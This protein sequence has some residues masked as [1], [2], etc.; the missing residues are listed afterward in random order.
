[1]KFK[2]LN[3]CTI[4]IY[5][6]LILLNW[7]TFNAIQYKIFDKNRSVHDIIQKQLIK[8]IFIDLFNIYLT[9]N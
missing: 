6:D 1:M 9:S 7:N 8:K 4:I 5:N 2:E 3:I